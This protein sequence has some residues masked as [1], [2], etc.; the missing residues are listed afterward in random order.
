MRHLR[1]H[2]AFFRS[3]KVLETTCPRAFCPVS[4]IERRDPRIWMNCSRARRS[5]ASLRRCR[6]VARSCA[7]LKNC[8]VEWPERRKL[9]NRS[10]NVNSFRM[11]FS[12]GPSR[13]TPLRGCLRFSGDI[14]MTVAYAAALASVIS[15]S[16]LALFQSRMV[17]SRQC[18]KRYCDGQCL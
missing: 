11:S 7:S 12:M 10:P 13:R 17:Q 16:R 1:S 2:A 14:S 5:M 4:V 6:Y 18:L 8:L 9:Y 15:V 3:A